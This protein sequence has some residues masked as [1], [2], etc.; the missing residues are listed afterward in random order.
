[1]DKQKSCWMACPAPD[2]I[3]WDEWQAFD[4]VEAVRTPPRTGGEM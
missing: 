4:G 2:P 3:P 1:M